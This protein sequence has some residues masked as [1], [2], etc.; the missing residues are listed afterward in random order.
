MARAE[1]LSDPKRAWRC[2]TLQALSWMP[3]QLAGTCKA[4]GRLCWD[5]VPRFAGK[6]RASGGWGPLPQLQ[7]KSDSVAVT[8]AFLILG[9]PD[10]LLANDLPGLPR[11]PQPAAACWTGAPSPAGGLLAPERPRLPASAR[12]HCSIAP[13]GSEG[14]YWFLRGWE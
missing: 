6:E 10:G 1:G 12:S 11:S 2:W 14:E 8:S 5:L 13:Q 9:R 3:L 7:K 4:F